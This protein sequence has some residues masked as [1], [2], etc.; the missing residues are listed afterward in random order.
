MASYLPLEYHSCLDLKLCSVLHMSCITDS[1]HF[2]CSTIQMFPY[3]RLYGCCTQTLV[4]RFWL[5]HPMPHISYGNGSG[6]SE[7]HVQRLAFV[8]C[9]QNRLNSFCI[10]LIL[11]F[12]FFLLFSLLHQL[13]LS[14]GSQQMEFLWLMTKMIITHLKK[15]VHVLLCPEMTRMSC[16]H[17]VERFPCS[18]WWH[19]RSAAF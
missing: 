15:Q 5:L 19:L 7:I 13:C 10:S 9:M 14:C 11:V 8:M 4:Q 17:L 12:F 18:T 6:L 16:P 1:V 3:C 2:S